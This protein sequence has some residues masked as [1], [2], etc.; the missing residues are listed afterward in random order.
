MKDPKKRHREPKETEHEKAIRERAQ[1]ECDCWYAHSKVCDA[2]A[3]LD[4]VQRDRV[5]KAALAFY[6]LRVSS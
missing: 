3:N 6:G 4:N 1:W 5:L 2:L